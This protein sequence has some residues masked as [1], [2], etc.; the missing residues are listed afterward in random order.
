M[1]WP[2]QKVELTR[3]EI[4][5]LGERHAA[6]MLRAKGYRLVEANARVT[7]GEIDLICSRG[8]TLI[9]VEVRTRT[10]DAF[11]TPGE[12]VNE[13]KQKRVTRAARRYLKMKKIDET[14][15]QYDVVEVIATKY[16]KIVDI[17]HIEAFIS[18]M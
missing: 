3:A 7:N 8:D 13:S 12:S 4:G 15:I 11:I 6:R 5:A 18:G 14:P 17:R 10:S 9:F 1:R 2:W 16:G